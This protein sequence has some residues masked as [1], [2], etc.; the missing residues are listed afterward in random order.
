[1][2]LTGDDLAR[3]E[4]A[5]RADL[6][7]PRE[8]CGAP[9]QSLLD[10]FTGRRWK[11][12]SWS[13]HYPTPRQSAFLIY[14]GREGLYGG[15]AGGG[16]TD[17]ALMAAAQ[18][19]CVP[20]YKA[21]IFRQTYGQLAQDGGLIERSK[22]WW[23]AY[24]S[25]NEGAH[26][27]TFPSGAT[28][29][30]GSLQYERD[31]HKYQGANYHFVYFDELTNWPTPGAWTYLFSRIRRDEAEGTNLPR[32]PHCGL[33]AGDVPLRSRAGTNPGGVGGKWVY[34][35]FV[36]P[37]RDVVAGKRKADPER[38]FI[39]SLLKD[40]PY[41]DYDAYLSSLS[42]LD[43]VERAQLENGDWDV[44]V[45]GAMF[46]R[47]TMPIVDDWPRDAKVVRYWD[48]AATE[49]DGK[50]NDP[51]WTAGGFVAV[52]DGQCWLVDMQ[53]F[54]KPPGPL[55]L[56]VKH[57][58]ETDGRFVPI[59]MEQEGGASGKITGASMVR[60]LLAGFI[61]FSIPKGRSKA[62][63]ARPL[64]AAAANGNV[65]VVRGEW[66]DDWFEEAEMFPKP[67]YHDDQVDAFSGGFNW[68]SGTS[69]PKRGGLQ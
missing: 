58:A 51:D 3:L 19:V 44:R 12:R 29:T 35:R 30:F 24:A 18:Y 52:K 26:R 48:F 62:E 59:V 55:E 27:W 7:T 66:N 15:A 10:K 20:G 38:I 43:P 46:D 23:S 50:N 60:H 41:L 56:H 28:I 34:D 2:T 5:I 57:V 4:P 8:A 37:W 47:F 11:A 13:P 17:A 31:K 39:P 69:G 21:I 64:S 33:S 32:C 14:Q 54:R 1:M 22:L 53:R 63:E 61:A 65:F 42:Q 49:D 36:A 9:V 67:G 16:K 45:K 40:N 25:Y 6:F 68:V